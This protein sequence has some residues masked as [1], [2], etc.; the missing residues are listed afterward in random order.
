MRLGLSHGVGI[1]GMTLLLTAATGCIRPGD[2]LNRHGDEIVVCGQLFHA[3]TPVVLW[4]DPGGYDA[5][6]A[7][8][9]F[10]P[11]KIMP[12]NPVDK[13]SPSRFGDRRNLPAELQAKV[14][15]EGWTLANLQEQ[16]D[17]F[18]FHYDV[19]GTSRRCFQVLQDM[20][21]L[22]VHF[23]LDLDGTLYQTLDLKERAWHAGTA[24]DRSVG[25]EIANIGAYGEKSKTTLDKWY[26]LGADGWPVATFPPEVKETGIRTPSFVGRPA[27]KELLKG[28]INGREVWQYDYT[29]EQYAALIKLVATMRR[30]FPKMTLD[31]PRNPD[32]SIR[33]DVFTN[34]EQAAFSGFMGHW[35]ESKGKVDPGPAFDWEGVFRG[36]RRELLWPG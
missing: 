7:H 31:A 20:R 6:E 27:R 19:C 10:E 3:G 25:V 26:S 18:V 36:A 1:A 15:R 17:Q 22:S 34:E 4:L 13:D 14:A 8:R 11:D 29:P 30:I 2:H 12:T 24:N 32:G 33:M 16:V 5:Y 9:H 23:L 35:H 28:T 21:G